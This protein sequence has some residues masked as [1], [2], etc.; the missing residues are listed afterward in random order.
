M[1]ADSER[2]ELIRSINEQAFLN[3]LAYDA[4]HGYKSDDVSLNEAYELYGKAWIKDRISRG[5]LNKTRTGSK[6]NSTIILSRYEIEC[7]KRAE[8]LIEEKYQRIANLDKDK[9]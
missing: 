9:R 8:K 1:N 7:L 4:W 3:A 2:L 6:A 5:L